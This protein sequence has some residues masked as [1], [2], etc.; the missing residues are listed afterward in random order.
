MN[1]PLEHRTGQPRSFG[2]RTID[3]LR[4]DAFVPS[5]AEKRTFGVRPA[6]RVHSEAELA[7]AR[8]AI[9]DR[10]SANLHAANVVA[11]AGLA[12]ILSGPTPA[13]AQ[14]SGDIPTI[15]AIEDPPA[16][17][18]PE[19]IAA[20]GDPAMPAPIQQASF[21]MGWRELYLEVFINGTSTKLIGNFK[22]TPDGALAVEPGELEEVGLKAQEI[23]PDGL[24]RLDRL[25][26][27]TFVIDEEN[28]RLYVSAPIESRSTRNIDLSSNV[29]E[30]RMA[31]TSGYGAVFNYS[32]FAA[33]SNLAESSETGSLEGVS[34]SFEA[35]AFSPFG[36]VSQTFLTGYTDGDLKGVTRMATVWSYSDQKR[37]LTYRAGDLISGGLSWTRPVFMGGLQIQRNFSLRSDLVTLPMPN[38]RGTAEVP[39]T[40][41]VYTRNNALA[42]SSKVGEGP[43]ELD[44]LPVAAGANETRIVLRD[45]L[46]RET[47]ATLPFFSAPDMLAPGLL[48]FSA[49]VGFAR[50]GY[51][52][53]SFNYDERPFGSMTARYGLTN[54]LTL[55]A[56][57]EGGQ[58]LINAGAGIV[59][60]LAMY[61]SAN[62]AAAA[63]SSDG[64]TG[65]L[66]A[67]SAALTYGDWSIFA[68]TQRTFGD[69][70]DIA[71]VT[72][73]IEQTPGMPILNTDMPRA[74][75]QLSVSLPPI[76]EGGSLSFSYTH[77][78]EADGASSQLVS[79]SYSQQV[80][81]RISA[82]AS[83]FANIEDS[84][85]F[86]VFAGLSMSFDNGISASA[87]TDY[88]DDGPAFSTSVARGEKIA[89]GGYGWRVRA[90]KDTTTRLAAAGSYRSPWARFGASVEQSDKNI[91]ANAQVD[92]AIAIAGGDIFAA[93]RIDD[94]FAVVDVGAPGVEVL[95]QN[96][97]VGKS[98]SRGK[99][100]VTGL[101]AYQP[102]HIAID[103]ANLP[104][105]ANIASTRNV[106]VPAAQSGVVVNFGVSEDPKAAIVALV[107][108]SGQPIEVGNAAQL[109]GGDEFVIGYDG[110]AYMT[111]LSASNSV[112]VTFEDGTSCAAQFD[113]KPA[114][115]EQIVIDGVQ[116]L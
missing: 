70:R 87:T 82:Y 115:G 89:D 107:D 114:K 23:G 21:A 14:S 34:A 109:E 59:F 2:K 31:P 56:H 27:V 4:R 105:E 46:G 18:M 71:S 9:N 12:V 92:G 101:N 77:V 81:N 67:A 60:P 88:G 90:S 17:A 15:A 68:R 79:A 113:Y 44:N 69:Y 54:W 35:R 40:L 83:A 64:A 75:D 19:A 72:A 6:F 102:N 13:A 108:A 53:D 42:Y 45:Q 24:V 7:L 112:T 93:N 32:L 1:G 74:V 78:E 103:P 96:R 116:C 63:S 66:F 80:T 30:D 10:S 26:G 104:V 41:E 99:K 91:R 51:G 55:Q 43:F 28:Q 39:S 100:L 85:N 20:Q 37:M 47:E 25:P 38:Y 57:A 49:E 65:A 110:Q 36:A 98:N 95:F 29:F 8:A 3:G 86:G 111:G 76:F 5:Q 58:D 94:A 84:R 22:E 16:P 73:Q 50:L 33:S 48:D 97:P 61:G 106:V 62:I 52:V 11:A